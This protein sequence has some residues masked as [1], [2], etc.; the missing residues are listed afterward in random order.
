MPEQ[1]QKI[2]SVSAVTF[3]ARLDPLTREE[4]VELAH[5][6]EILG[7][8]RRSVKHLGADTLSRL[9]RL[10]GLA[11]YSTGYEWLDH[12]YLVRRGIVLSYLKNYSTDTVAEHVMGLMLSMS[13]RIHLSYDR[14]RGLAPA[15]TSLCG[16][17]LKGKKLGIIGLGRIG[18]SVGYCQG[19]GGMG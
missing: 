13:R 17:E 15:D 11:V 3:H 4:L 7:V 6:A 5:D 12:Y 18:R 16:W 8:T 14:V 2:K 10:K 9:P 1:V 19:N